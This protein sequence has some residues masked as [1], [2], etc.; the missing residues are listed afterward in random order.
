MRIALVTTIFP[1]LSQTFVIDQICRLIDLG[2]DVR[3]YPMQRGEGDVPLRSVDTYNLV[4]R[5][6][7]PPHL[8]EGTSQRLRAIIVLLLSLFRRSPRLFSKFLLSR[9]PAIMGR[10][11]LLACLDQFNEATTCDVVLCHFGNT[12]LRAV[13]LA[14]F[15]LSLGPIATVFHGADISRY[16]DQSGPEIYSPLFNYGSLFLPISNTWNKRLIELGCPQEK[17]RVHHMGVDCNIH[18]P[19][20][21]IDL[22]SSPIRLLSVCRLVEKKGIEFA[23]RAISSLVK[24]EPTAQL[25]YTIIGNGP[26]LESLHQLVT[27]LNLDEVITFAGPLPP[28]QVAEHFDSAHILLAPSVTATDGDKEGIPVAI[29]EAMARGLPVVST[30]HSG[31]PELIE[32]GVNGYLV[33]ERDHEALAHR[34]FILMNERDQWAQIAIAARQKVMLDHNNETLARILESYL[35]ECAEEAQ[36]QYS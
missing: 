20:S 24:R 25:N 22:N 18:S 26:L 29:M 21:S 28:E 23:I 5:T 8:P 4:A 19:S 10:S 35:L 33:P 11:E 27:N 30:Y 2:H 7:Y 14:K 36:R 31:I 9:R 6:T 13:W 34:L 15:G 32:D 1:T 12:G 16:V 3:I 17:I